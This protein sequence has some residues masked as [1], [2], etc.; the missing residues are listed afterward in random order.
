M[1]RRGFP[2][3]SKE[4]TSQRTHHISVRLADDD[5]LAEPGELAVGGHHAAAVGHVLGGA[6]AVAHLLRLRRR[7]RHVPPQLRRQRLPQLQGV[8]QVRPRSYHTNA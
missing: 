3:S 5:V 6:E 4:H 1:T 2:A 8:L 7:L